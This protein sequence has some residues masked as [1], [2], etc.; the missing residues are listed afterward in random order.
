MFIQ[1]LPSPKFEGEVYPWGSSMFSISLPDM[2]SIAM[3][4][5]HLGALYSTN[6]F[7]TT[8]DH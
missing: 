3:I 6:L 8:V 7:N 5:K 4:D 2:V 1:S